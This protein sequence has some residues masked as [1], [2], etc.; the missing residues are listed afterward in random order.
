MAMISTLVNFSTFRIEKER[1][2]SGRP[3]ECGEVV[4]NWQ[5]RF[6]S[7]PLSEPEEGEKKVGLH[8][9]KKNW[10][11]WKEKSFRPSSYNSVERA[12]I[13]MTAY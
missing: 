12:T 8:E 1:S 4:M 5:I 11:S 10:L 6:S 9:K 2:N 7:T 13:S 3:R